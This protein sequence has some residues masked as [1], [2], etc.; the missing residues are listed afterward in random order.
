M[1]VLYCQNKDK[2]SSQSIDNQGICKIKIL[3]R[4]MKLVFIQKSQWIW[5]VYFV[6]VN[7]LISLWLLLNKSRNQIQYG[8][9]WKK[10]K[11]KRRAWIIVLMKR[12][13][14]PAI[15]TYT[16]PNKDDTT[17][18]KQKSNK[19]ITIDKLDYL[20]NFSTDR[21]WKNIWKYISV[22]YKID[23]RLYIVFT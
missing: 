21:K 5:N 9:N 7:T 2:K 11:K 6:C 10:F 14:I 8:I 1:C 12:V 16:D 15:L 19:I 23:L 20:D 17:W 22:S 18:M 4:D 13:L 3:V